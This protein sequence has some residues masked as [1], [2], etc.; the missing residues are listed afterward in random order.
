MSLFSRPALTGA[1]AAAVL[2]WRV[3]TAPAAELWRDWIVVLA[4]YG[5]FAAL[6]PRARA[7]PTVT[8]SVA[9]YLLGIYAHG[10]LP[11]A[12]AALGL[13]R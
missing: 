4:L 8:A 7:L 3:L 9:A 1:A 10:Q 12:L 13:W 5:A 2:A 11:Y 6:A